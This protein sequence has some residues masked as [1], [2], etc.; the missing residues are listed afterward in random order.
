MET[1]FFAQFDD[2]RWIIAD[3]DFRIEDRAWCT[4][5][6][7]EDARLIALN[8][9]FGIGIIR[10]IVTA[11]DAARILNYENEQRRSVTSV[12]TP[13]ISCLDRR[14]VNGRQTRNTRSR[15]DRYY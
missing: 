9:S 8:E 11:V 1:S 10:K 6:N 15:I 5:T 2:N 7:P 3:A 4:F 14:Q 13:P 12:R